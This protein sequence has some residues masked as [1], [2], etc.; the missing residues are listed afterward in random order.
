[1]VVLVLVAMLP[2]ITRAA[3]G[4]TLGQITAGGSCSPYNVGL[5]FD[6]TDLFVS[7]YG[8][9]LIDIISPA[10]GSLVGQITVSGESILGAL[11]YDP[12]RS[13][14]WVCNGAERVLL[15]NPADGSVEA[16]FASNGCIDGLA[17]DGLDDTLWAGPDQDCDVTHYDTDG[18]VIAVFDACPLLGGR[19]KSGIA[20]AGGKLYVANASFGEVYQVEKDFSAS[21]LLFGSG[22]VWLEDLECDDVTF[23]PK[24]A[25]WIQDAFDRVLT[26]VEIPT[27]ACP[28]G[29]G[30]DLSLA[31]SASPDPVGVGQILTYTLT[32]TNI[33]PGAATG[34]TV[35]DTLPVGATFE[36][37][38]T[39]CTQSTGT[40]TCDL[41]PIAKDG[42]ATVTI[43]VTPQSSGTITNTATVSGEQA[44]SDESNNT[45]TAETTVQSGPEPPTLALAP[46][47]ATNQV[48]TSHTVTAT[49][50]QDGS[51]VSGATVLFSVTGANTGS[52]SGATDGSG[53]AS[54]SYTGTNAGSD[55]ITACYDAN[56][57]GTCDSDEATAT[58]TKTWT[59]APPAGMTPGKGCGDRNH[60]HERYGE[61]ATKP[62]KPV[63]GNRP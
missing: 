25:L 36:S 45:A 34:V 18:T 14:L 54:F 40:V 11:S 48:G 6:G 30:A 37:A 39:G 63:G 27:G 50:T 44:D 15:V 3:T 8:N 29:G 9:N 10:D 17:Y 24:S 46:T 35:T 52:G 32:V 19:G 59:S 4:D 33:G 38:S 53:N 51:G 56:S 49:L 22:G 61:C 62:G 2:T 16:S 5:T 28:F 55:T 58:A 47:S 41:G 43:T 42:S 12:S 13:R 26:A 31:K 60:V 20:V 7:C 23:A 57:S 1:V 21:S